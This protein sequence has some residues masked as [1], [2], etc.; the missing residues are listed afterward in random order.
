M[1]TSVETLARVS[2]G[3]FEDGDRAAVRELLAPDIC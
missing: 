2:I 3:L 1:A